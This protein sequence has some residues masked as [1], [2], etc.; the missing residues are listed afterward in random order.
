MPA[1]AGLYLGNLQ[2]LGD[3]EKEGFT[4]IISVNTRVELSTVTFRTL[5]GQA[6]VVVRP[7]SSSHVLSD[8]LLP[9]ICNTW[10]RI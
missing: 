6:V 1:C 4:H 5:I 2:A 8:C 3:A 10:I 9:V 7:L